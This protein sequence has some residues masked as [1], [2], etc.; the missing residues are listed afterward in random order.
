MKY[1]F[2]LLVAMLPL[3]CLMSVMAADTPAKALGL[4]LQALDPA[5]LQSIEAQLGKR[6]GVMITQVAP[7]SPAAQAGCVQGE[8]ILTVG[9]QVVDSPQAIEQALAGKTGAVELVGIVIEGEE[10]KIVKRALVVKAD[11]SAAMGVNP[12]GVTPVAVDAET[13]RKLKALDDAHQAGIL[14]DT[15]YASKRAELLKNTAPAI[16]PATQQK[17]KALED[18][19]AAGILS[20]AEFTQKKTELLKTAPLNTANNSTARKG[21]TY[22]H[23]I[24]F[25]FWYP[26]GWTV[27]EVDGALQLVPA[28]QAMQNNQP[29]EMYFITGQPLEGTNITQVNDPQVVA[30]LDQL[31]LQ[32][33]SPALVRTKAPAMLQTTNGQGMQLEWEVQGEQGIVHA[34]IY[35]C[36]LKNY[37]VIFAA[38]GVK[39]KILAREADLK[40]IFASFGLEAGK[41]DP[42]VAGVWQLFST[43]T[44][45]NEDNVNFTSDDPRRAS[46]VSDEQTTLELRPDGVVA[47]TSLSRTIAGGAGVWIDSGEQR[48]VKQGR[49]NA[50]NGTLFIMWNDGSMDSWRYGLVNDGGAL[51]LK[52]Q[53]GNQVE[54]WQKR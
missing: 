42:A 53:V 12:G 45:R 30:Y 20:D 3:T 6:A 44:L 28:D 15:E 10:V 5:D 18:A 16:D 41:Q 11:L 48:E 26:E 21:R 7:N 38:F 34:R 32:Q 52:L 13:Q 39:D 24:G 49:W 33:L 43:R 47:R 2:L 4:T 36:I 17:L 1:I 22:Q 35:S 50:G 14:N 29:V 9:G 8:V 40:A 54:F 46:S 37:G 23:V 19:H 31:V 25:S 27:K 51:S